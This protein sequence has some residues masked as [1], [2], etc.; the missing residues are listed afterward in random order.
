MYTCT[1]KCKGTAQGS[2]VMAKAKATKKVEGNCTMKMCYDKGEG[3]AVSA[4]RWGWL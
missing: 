1:S 3:T 2:D 4:V